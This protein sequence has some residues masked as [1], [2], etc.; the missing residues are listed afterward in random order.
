MDFERVRSTEKPIRTSASSRVS[1]KYIPELHLDNKILDLMCKM[2]TTDSQYI[3]RGS[4]I[5]LQKFIDSV[6]PK[7]YEDAEKK[8]LVSFIRKGLEA[9]LMFNINN[10]ELII[11]HINGGILDDG[12][13]DINSFI[14]LDAARINWLNE[15]ISTVLKYDYVYTHIDKI[16]DV[17]TRFKTSDYKSKAEIIDEFE[18][19]INEAQNDF[20]RSRNEAHTEATFSLIDGEF[21]DAVVDAYN[22]VSSPRRKLRTGMQGMNELLGG[23]FESGRVYTFFG[24]PG[25]GK[26]TTL[27]N[28]MYQL[29][30]YNTDYKPKDPT[31][32][33]TIVLLTME[34]TIVES[35][36]RLFGLSCVG[37]GGMVDYSVQDVIQMLRTDGELRLDDS[38]P[39]NILIKYKPT[40]SVDTSYLYTLCEDLEDR[41]MEVI[42]MFQ[43]YIGRIR[44]TQYNSD[45]RLEY[46]AVTDEFKV[47]AEIRDIPVITASQL[48]RDASKHID[49]GRKNNKADLVRFIG[50]SNI[51][52]SMLVLNNID[53]GFVIAPEVT[54]MNERYLGVQ[55]IKIRYRAGDREYVYLPYLGDSIRFIEDLGKEPTFKTTMRRELDLFSGGGTF[56]QSQY[57]T[58]AIIEIDDNQTLVDGNDENLF[59][60]GNFISGDTP[61][62]AYSQESYSPIVFFNPAVFKKQ[63]VPQWE[64]PDEEYSPIKFY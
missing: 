61:A 24:L 38:S 53:A 21:E 10:P 7:E 13:V 23:G 20:R 3:K 22:Q 47:F 60:S 9:R 54:E 18:D 50:R 59:T 44:S 52:E 30:K 25:E 6:D 42:A 49:E 36:E 58:N 41:G 26:S 48:N 31:K 62:A 19:C 64:I 32:I 15:M 28:L 33:P 8:K 43:D 63:E 40:N 17:C 56:R 1:N 46:G 2:I 27:L 51:S 16:L 4:L 37:A 35:I 34:N 55:R 39:I 12:I 45:S 29:K 11:R 5:N 14:G 57:H